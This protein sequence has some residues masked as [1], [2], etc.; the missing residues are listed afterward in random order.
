[1]AIPVKD[2]EQTQRELIPAGTYIARCY[3]MI[4][5]GTNKDQYMGQEKMI[6]KVR[7][8]WEIP[9]LMKVFDEA[10]GEQP[11]AIHKDYT[12]SLYE[13]ANLRADLESWRGQ[14][15]KD[16]ETDFKRV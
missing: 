10:K 8:S 12:L 1:M 11:M 9:A 4:H 5:I 3:A 13:K 2:D 6:N 15:F 14:A 16:E 7:F